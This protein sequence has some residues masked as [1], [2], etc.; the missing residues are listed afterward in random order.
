MIKFNIETKTKD[1]LKDELLK[2][3]KIGD[4]IL[5]VN[6]KIYIVLF[7]PISGGDIKVFDVS[8]SKIISAKYITIK[9]LKFTLDM[10]VEF[11]NTTSLDKYITSL[12][13]SGEISNKSVYF[14]I[15]DGFNDVYYYL[16]DDIM[17]DDIMNDNNFYIKCFNISKM[18]HT[19]IHRDTSIIIR[20]VQQTFDKSSISGYMSAIN[21]KIEPL[22]PPNSPV[23]TLSSLSV[24][25]TFIPTK[26]L[27]VYMGDND[28]ITNDQSYVIIEKIDKR[29]HVFNFITK[30]TYILDECDDDVYKVN[31][32]LTYTTEE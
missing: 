23:K 19:Q 30:Q 20:T 9:D 27:N 7:L 22:F 31:L 5:D 15:I 26:D 18:C 2:T 10:D 29:C 17:N 1:E 16:Y 6:Y 4:Y 21:F 12:N 32:T 25:D 28:K 8:N 3:L 24:G 11:E 13:S 14:N